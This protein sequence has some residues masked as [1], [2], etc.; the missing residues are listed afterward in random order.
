LDV[1]HR[2]SSH[3]P[4]TFSIKFSP[5]G[6]YLWSG[7]RDAKIAIRNTQTFAIEHI[8]PAHRYTVNDIAFSKNGKYVA[9]ASRDKTI[10]I[11]AAESFRLLKVIDAFKY[12]LHLNSVNRLLWCGSTIYSASDDKTIGVFSVSE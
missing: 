4:A 5:C 11:W 12:D 6:N 1:I 7:G 8:I 10:K 9:T 2:F 3:P